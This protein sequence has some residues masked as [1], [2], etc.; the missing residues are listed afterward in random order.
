MEDYTPIAMVPNAGSYGD[1]FNQNPGSEIP[2]SDYGFSWEGSGNTVSPSGNT[3]LTYLNPNTQS[4]WDENTQ[5]RKH[6]FYVGYYTKKIWRRKKR[7]ASDADN[8]FS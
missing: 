6:T 4:W 1:Y 5:G 8:G 2:I 7:H 3:S